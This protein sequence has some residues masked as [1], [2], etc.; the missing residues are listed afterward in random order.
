[1]VMDSVGVGELPDADQ[2]GDTGSN[3]LEHAAQAVGGLPLPNL[4][5]L[6]LGNLVNLHGNGS[7]S[8][9]VGLAGCYGK[10][11]ELSKGKDTTTGHWEMMGIVVEKPFPL[12]PNGFP[13]ELI[14]EF[15][16]AVGRKT[17]GNRPASGTEIIKEL[18]EEHYRTGSPIVY[19]SGDSVFQVAAHEDVVPLEELYRM[20]KI[21]RSL[22]IEEHAVGRVIARPFVGKPG[23]FA[24]THHRHDYSLE[25]FSETVLDRIKAQGLDCVSVGK[26]WDIFAG[27]GLSRHLPAGPNQEV[28]EQTFHAVRD[29][30][31]KDGLV[32]A[33]LVDFDM[34]YNHR[35]D[36]QGLAKAMTA[37]DE[38]LP[39]LF[40]GMR[41]DDVLMI[42]ADHGNDPTDQST[43]HSREYVPILVYGK[44]A[45]KG[46]DLGTRKSF[47][48]CGQTV[49]EIF[50]L[51]PIPAGKS[52]LR[53]IA[54]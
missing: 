20:C 29:I 16:K 15:E 53:E 34:L 17:I 30:N 21:A 26:I 51:K 35:Q 44:E 2:Y 18:G 52:F 43:D 25:P 24:R 8:S 54:S 9:K 36:P 10:M 48:D 45:A 37:F 46:V 33:N 41:Q 31:F 23:D 11:A 1:M 42:T 5:K 6:G 19:T 3:T 49:A 40:E 50:G 7:S 14:R 38:F 13:K 22:L 28:M 47:A 27:R 32:F 12:Y 39:R 4:E